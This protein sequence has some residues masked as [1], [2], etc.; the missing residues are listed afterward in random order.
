[1]VEGLGYCHEQGIAHRDLKPEN[2]LLGNNY[3]V[4]LVDFGFATSFKNAQ[5]ENFKMVTAL[6]TPGYAA[7]EILKRSKYDNAVD[8]FSLGVIL[9]I[10]IAGFPPFQEAKAEAD[11][12]FHK[13]KTKRFDLFWKAHER[14]AKFTPEAKEILLG[15][16]AADPAERWT[17]SKIKNSK[18]WNQKTLTQQEAVDALLKR[19]KKVEKEKIAK[20][21]EDP[22]K[23]EHRGDNTIHAPPMKMYRP[24]NLFYCSPDK[25]ADDIRSLLVDAVSQESMG[26]VEKEYYATGDVEA[27]VCPDGVEQKE[28]KPWW[29]FTFTTQLKETLGEL[30]MTH[31]FEGGVYIREDTSY[32]PPASNPEWRRNAVYFKRHSGPAHKW[33]KVMFKLQLMVGFFHTEAPAEPTS[34]AIPDVSPIKLEVEPIAA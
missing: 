16:L 22:L 28:W 17:I 8:I 10:T 4:K 18:W 3:E 11:W 14:T 23:G 32:V 33:M 13:L 19:K 7:P 25:C 24:A 30:T 20:D 15:M 26:N 31:K 12:W 1:M 9:F 6:G 21:Q 5:G 34:S 2:C 27:P 29:D